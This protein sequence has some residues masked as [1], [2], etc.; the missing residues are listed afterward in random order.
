MRPTARRY[1]GPLQVLVMAKAPV[2]GRVKTRL[3]PPLSGPEAAAVAEA[4]LADTLDSVLTCHADSKVLALEGQPGLW[5]PSGIDVIP[6]RGEGLGQRL[7]NAWAD[8]RHR[9]SGWGLQLGMD[10]PQVTS[11][12]LDALLSKLVRTQPGAARTA[13][14]G[15]ALDGGWWVIGLPGSD[16]HRVFGGLPTST[17]DAGEAQRRRLEALRLDVTS[18]PTRCDI[19][20]ID[21]LRGVA[22]QFPWTRTAV[23]A[24]EVVGWER[25]AAGRSQVA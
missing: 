15:L 14:L 6:Q 8:T 1:R 22:A 16:P 7:A 12:E 5:L 2:P 18:A 23:V 4:A 9:T 17:P 13:L 3:S 10:T 25:M 20:T 24:G 11:G 21:D 19:D